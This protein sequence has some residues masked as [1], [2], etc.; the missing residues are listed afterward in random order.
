MGSA[1]CRRGFHGVPVRDRGAASLHRWLFVPLTPAICLFVYMK[2][3]GPGSQS[4]A[5][6]PPASATS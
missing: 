5:Q 6:A 1:I 2:L 4:A 3:E